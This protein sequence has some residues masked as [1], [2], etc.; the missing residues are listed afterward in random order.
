MRRD[1]LVVPCFDEAARFRAAAVAELLADPGIH[2]ILVDDGSRDGTRAVLESAAAAHPGRVTVVALDRNRGKAEAVRLGLLRALEDGADAAGY[3]DA[4][5]STPPD[6]L[7]RLVAVQRES[8]AA[9]VLGCRH[10]H[11][12]ADI[13]RSAARH[14]TGRVFATIAAH[15]LG[16]AVYDTQC[17]A[18]VFAA[19]DALRAALA[20]PFLSRWSFDVELLGRLMN[21]AERRG[22][23]R[24]EG[25]VEVPLRRWHDAGGSKLGLV[26]ALRATLELIPVARA[27]RRDQRRKRQST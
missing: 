10:A 3:A 15:V 9:A 26:S 16:C 17:G 22:R 8:G 13:R 7:L 18:K 1:A 12:G 2:V 4:D 25:F 19:G 20:E 24:T 5:F 21:E 23:K 14:Y 6:E 11:L 27:L